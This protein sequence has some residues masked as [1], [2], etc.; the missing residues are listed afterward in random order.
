[1]EDECRQEGRFIVLTAGR[2][3]SECI[4]GAVSYAYPATVAE[5]TINLRVPHVGT[6]DSVEITHPDTGLANDFMPGNA[7]VMVYLRLAD[8]RCCG[9]S[10]IYLNWAGFDTGLAECAA[11]C[12]EVEIGQAGHFMPGRVQTND[13]GFAGS[14][15]GMLAVSAVL[16]Q[17]Q[18]TMPWR[19]RPKWLLT[20]RF[21]GSTFA[22]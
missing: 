14:D 6:G 21:P 3:D 4:E 7:G 11:C 1:M 12:T 5:I 8:V 20:D 10:N 22:T 2:A 16:I 13:G 17:R 18:A 15:A 9:A 19:G